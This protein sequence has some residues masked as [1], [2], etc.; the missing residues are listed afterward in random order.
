[1]TLGYGRRRAHRNSASPAAETARAE[2]GEGHEF[3]YVLG[4]AGV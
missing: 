1:V 4:G 2:A 3:T